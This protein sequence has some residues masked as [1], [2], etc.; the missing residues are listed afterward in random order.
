MSQS[1]LNWIF[2]AVWLL[3]LCIRNFPHFPLS[4]SERAADEWVSEHIATARLRSL[5]SESRFHIAAEKC[6]RKCARHLRQFSDGSVRIFGDVWLNR[7]EKVLWTCAFH[8]KREWKEKNTAKKY[9]G[10]VLHN[11]WQQM[12]TKAKRMFEPRKHSQWRYES[13][14]IE[15][16]EH[17]S[18]KFIESSRRVECAVWVALNVRRSRALVYRCKCSK[19]DNNDIA[20]GCA[21][22]TV[23]IS[24][25][26]KQHIMAGLSNE[27]HVR[28]QKKRQ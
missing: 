5:L 20:R 3:S 14:H 13:M 11:L 4:L 22:A 6:R 23:S 15:C 9:Y 10:L 27:T 12:Y 2:H 26:K 8:S 21:R 25:T 28:L 16:D 17:K 1:T 19:I 7:D 18:L 24:P